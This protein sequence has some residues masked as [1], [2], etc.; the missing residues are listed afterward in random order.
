MHLLGGERLTEMT[1][2][3][4]IIQVKVNAEQQHE[5]ADD[6]LKIRAVVRADAQRLVA[7]S[8]CARRAEGVDE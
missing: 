3:Q 1:Q 2:Q 5:H 7:E 6:D 8:A 4:E